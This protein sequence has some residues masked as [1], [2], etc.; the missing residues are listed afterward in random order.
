VR[1]IATT[2][3]KSCPKSLVYGFL[4]CET[5]RVHHASNCPLPSVVSLSRYSV[6][7]RT[8]HPKLERALKRSYYPLLYARCKPTSRDSHSYSTM[9]KGLEP[10]NIHLNG[11]SSSPELGE[12]LI[13]LIH[14]MTLVCYQQ[15]SNRRV[16]IGFPY[17]SV[18]KDGMKGGE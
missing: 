6:Y 17:D 2:C 14:S 4:V 10:Y 16:L 8:N 1:W 18:E 9:Y 12:A 15:Q 7:G 11:V 5:L 3:T 13:T